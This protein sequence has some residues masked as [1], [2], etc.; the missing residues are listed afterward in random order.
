M[1]IFDAVRNGDIIK[2]HKLLDS[3]INPN[4]RDK[5]D[6]TPLIAIKGRSYKCCK[7][8]IRTWCRS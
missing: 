6:H 5:W 2:V 7:I 1:D 4:I 3:G 8:V